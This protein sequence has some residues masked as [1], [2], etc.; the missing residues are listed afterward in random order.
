MH[1]SSTSIGGLAAALAK[2]QSSA[3]G[4]WAAPGIGNP[5]RARRRLR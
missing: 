3:A 5:S 4:P 2:A 1:R